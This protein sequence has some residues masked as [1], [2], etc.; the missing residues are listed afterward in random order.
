MKIDAGTS[1]LYAS[2]T[3]PRPGQPANGAG[4]ASF[5]ASLAASTAATARSEL[6][7]A[8]GGVDFTSMTRLEMREWVNEQIRS[9]KMSLDESLPFMWMTMKIPADGTGREV[10][11]LNDAE[12]INFVQRALDGIKGAFSR[13]DEATRKRLEFA[14]NLM[15]KHQGG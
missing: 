13:N 9:G 8:R 4:Q 15:R 12:R 7:A 3:T 2:T 1:Y 14:L 10:S 5:A 6:T 11:V